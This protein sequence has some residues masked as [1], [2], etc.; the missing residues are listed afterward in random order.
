MAMTPEEILAAS[1][2]PMQQAVANYAAGKVAMAHMAAEKS[3]DQQ[4][5]LELLNARMAGEKDIAKWHENAANIRA[6]SQE[7]IWDKRTQEAQ[8]KAESQE[9]ARLTYLDKRD[10]DRVNSSYIEGIKKYGGSVP[11]QEDNESDKAYTQHLSDA[12]RAA[13]DKYN[14][15]A[16]S[17]I[18]GHMQTL[19]ALDQAQQNSARN[20]A[21]VQ[22]PVALQRYLMAQPD[23]GT[24]A[25]LV[26]LQKLQAD[27]KMSFDDAVNSVGL[28]GFCSD[29]K[30]GLV[31]SK[32]DN[33]RKSDKDRLLVQGA[34]DRASA[35]NPEAARLA[36]DSAAGALKAPPGQSFEEAAAALAAKLKAGGAGGAVQPYAPSI[37]EVISG[38][39]QQAPPVY[40][41]PG[42][43][44]AQLLSPLA[45]TPPAG[46]AAN[47]NYS[48]I[49]DAMRKTPGYVPPP[50][51]SL[52]GMAL[53]PAP[54]AIIGGT[55]QTP[56]TNSGS[57]E[58][59]E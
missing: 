46:M 56:V 44:L 42:S 17:V 55:P 54:G 12:F 1:L 22:G 15:N 27:N 9:Q 25:K 41:E 23:P 21:A 40:S 7:R 20:F 14:Q 43:T 32:M 38:K 52:G 47:P 18:S 10:R 29:L 19:N 28:G 57:D 35:A 53:T 37:N 16:A 45:L 6:D 39:S 11:G 26:Q 51:I 33:Y 30:Q 2:N 50:G 3:I 5:A 48:L 8:G 31:D 34:I 49:L 4:N 24:Q 59:D 13:Q 36:L 58:D